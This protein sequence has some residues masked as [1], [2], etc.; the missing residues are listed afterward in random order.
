MPNMENFEMFLKSR[1]LVTVF[2]AFLTLFA[3]L[4]GAAAQEPSQ[5]HLEAAKKAIAATRSTTRL[6]EILPRMAQ[7]A[8]GELIRN[9]PD[10]EEQI[11]EIVDSAAINLA[12]RRGDLESEVAQIFVRV[13][14]EEELREITAFFESEAGR[15][16]LDESPVILREIDR[17]ARVWTN[18]VRRDLGAAVREK[19]EE[20]GLQ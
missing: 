14:S 1:V 8:K 19:M 3:M 12:A 16:F 17:A 9:R 7:N 13:F 20:A 5:S 18:G 11:T 6:D 4:A 10:Q 2:S 15:K